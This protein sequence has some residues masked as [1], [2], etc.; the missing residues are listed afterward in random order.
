MKRAKITSISC[1]S[2]LALI[3]IGLIGVAVSAQE[4]ERVKQ[5]QTIERGVIVEPSSRIIAIPPGTGIGV[6]G[7]VGQVSISQGEGSAGAFFGWGQD[8]IQTA[9]F[10]SAE[11]AFDNKIVEG[12]P[13][14]GAFLYESIQTLADGNR[15]INRS[16]T[17]I[18]RDSQGR[19]RREQEFGFSF[20]YGGGDTKR[21]SIQIFD[22]ILE[23]QYILDPQN[24]IARELP[25]RPQYT[26]STAAM[27]RIG[28]AAAVYPP[29]NISGGVLQGSAIKRIQP[30]YPQVA[31]V[32]RASGPVQVEVTI[33]EN[34]N[35][36]A[37]EASSGH[38][39]LREPA[40][41]AAKQWQFKP[42]EVDGKAVKVKGQL[43]FNFA[44]TD[45][46]EELNSFTG[47]VATATPYAFAKRM[48]ME[49]RTEA[50]GKQ[51]IEGIEAEGTRTINTIPA[52]TMGNERPIE[53]VF[54]RWY[55][56]ELQMVIMSSS[57]DPRMGVTTQRLVNI[58]RSEPDPSLFQ[59]PSDY[60]IETAPTPRAM[61]LQKV[62]EMERRKQNNQ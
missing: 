22:P 2:A 47:A 59:V 24:R 45:K 60:T 7:Q 57:S 62:L 51:N 37:A 5:E 13:F 21:K 32:A 30:V 35:V 28:G 6:A 53:M 12:A 15:I 10:L 58:I 23:H 19:T 36:I 16:T 17:A 52:G 29:T 8:G 1:L 31:K 46:K 44:F 18:Y 27:P 50:L 38:P 34:G 26:I 20:S 9:Q 39:L 42:T 61:D 11:M 54:E 55:S 4:K 3:A 40:V 33:D 43:T 48:N 41:D 56:P 49:S 25:T 14:S